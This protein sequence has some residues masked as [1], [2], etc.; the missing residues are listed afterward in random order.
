MPQP[1]RFTGAYL[2]PTG[3]YKMG[4]RYYDPHLGRFPQSDPSGRET[5]SYLYATGD[6]V[7]RTDPTG[8]FSLSD[9]LN[10][11]AAGTLGVTVTAALTPVIGPLGGA[12]VGG[13]AGGA[14]E[15]TWTGGDLGDSVLACAG[16]AALGAVGHG[17]SGAQAA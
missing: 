8:L 2:D 15:A 13:C 1:Y 3:S 16:G 14:V 7:N 12:I 9:G 4:A 11:I 5:N 10:S 6:P 17:F